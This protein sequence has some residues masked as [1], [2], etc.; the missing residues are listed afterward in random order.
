MIPEDIL[1]PFDSYSKRKMSNM[2]QNPSGKEDWRCALDWFIEIGVIPT[3]HPFYNFECEVLQFAQV[4]SDGVLLCELINLLVPHTIHDITYNTCT[5]NACINNVSAFLEAIS[6]HFDINEEE[7]FDPH[8]LI[9]FEDFGLFLKTMSK[10]SHH[11]LAIAKGA[12]PFDLESDR[13]HQDTNTNGE[14]PEDIYTNLQQVGNYRDHSFIELDN[15]K[16]SWDNSGVYQNQPRI[17]ELKD[18]GKRRPVSASASTASSNS[19]L[20]NVSSLHDSF[21]DSNLSSLSSN[22]PSLPSEVSPII[23]SQYKGNRQYKE[24]VAYEPI[25]AYVEED[26]Y[27]DEEIYSRLMDY[28]KKVDITPKPNGGKLHHILDELCNTEQNYLNTLEIINKNFRITLE[29]YLDREV[30]KTIFMNVQHLVPFHTKLLSSLKGLLAQK[31]YEVSQCFSLYMDKFAL[32]CEYAS[33]VP[34][35]IVKVKELNENP[36]I[37]KIMQG[38]QD[39]S[40][41][42]FPL[43][44]LLTMPIQRVLKYPL[45]IKELIKNSPDEEAKL[46]QK[47]LL[48]MEDIAKH[49]NCSKNDYEK[50]KFVTELYESIEFLPQIKANVGQLLIDG[51][52]KVKCGSIVSDTKIVPEKRAVFLFQRAILV[53]EKK[54]RAKSNMKYIFKEILYL[55]EYKTEALYSDMPRTRSD[56]QYQSGLI[57]LPL[58][59]TQNKNTVQFYARTPLLANNWNVALLKGQRFLNPKDGTD[60]GHQFQVFSTNQTTRCTVCDKILWGLYDQGYNCPLCQELCHRLCIANAQ[61]CTI[62]KSRAHTFDVP[63]DTSHKPTI[64]KRNPTK[65]VYTSNNTTPNTS[66]KLVYI[67]LCDYNADPHPGGSAPILVFMKDDEISIV[68]STDRDWWEGKNT[69][70]KQMGLFPARMVGIKPATMSYMDV[71]IG[72]FQP[73][74]KQ[75]HELPRRES[76]EDFHHKLNTANLVEQPWYVGKMSRHEAELILDQCENGVFLMRESDQRPGEYAIAVRYE[77]APKHI[78]ILHNPKTRKFFMVEGQ[79]F[80]TLVP[81]VEYYQAHSLNV[82]F[83]GIHTSLQKPYWAYTN[84]RSQRNLN[85][86]QKASSVTQ[87]I[88]NQSIRPAHKL[89][90]GSNR[91]PPPP[92]IRM[93]PPSVVYC[94]ALYDFE[95][96]ESSELS[97]RNGQNIKIIN[98]ETAHIGWWLGESD[99]RIGLFPANY[100]RLNE[101]S[102]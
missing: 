18:S 32:Y 15:D 47:T 23:P 66:N 101:F 62:G 11:K 97:F 57:C 71:Q 21:F 90:A 84:A 78:R 16:L 38:C 83:Q 50:L 98:K 80:S 94:Q 53:C 70:T 46:L 34:D 39:S 8:D 4:I 96:N 9:D 89:S 100:V 33:H 19:T 14:E 61:K 88:P 51:E 24:A 55:N 82:C 36:Q 93:K 40:K 85:I 45:L 59:S 102:V 69:R 73:P 26:P 77:E 10:I 3:S 20:S 27:G 65:A 76:M 74:N 7:A 28:Q 91:P 56:E 12:Q 25:Y 79:P 72:Q 29:Q 35:A 58:H 13:P 42:K 64:M 75:H 44:D 31:K 54:K 48:N 2:M 41:Q 22:I 43:K 1:F 30:I 92:K 63:L 86:S 37:C 52:M 5:N 6:E 67:A 60:N 81:L 68:S 87:L 17:N 95:A 99:G 49:I